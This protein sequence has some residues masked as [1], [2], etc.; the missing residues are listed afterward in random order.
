MQ[1]VFETLGIDKSADTSTIRKAYAKAIKQ[2]DPATEAARFQRIREAYEWA[3]QWAKRVEATAKTPPSVLVHGALDNTST[4]SVAPTAS[5]TR[6]TVPIDEAGELAQQVFREFVD[7]AYAPYA[8]P[9]G[10]ILAAYSHDVRL[11]SLDAKALFEQAVLVRAFARPIDVFLLDKACDLFIWETSSRHLAALRPDLVHRM[12]RQQTLRRLLTAG[13]AADHETLA[14]AVRLYTLIKRKPTTRVEPWQIANANRVLD[15]HAA[16][17]HELNERFSQEAFDWWRQKLRT[18]ASLS[19]AYDERHAQE[20]K[21]IPPRRQ[22]RRSRGSPI[23]W[24][25]IFPFLG[26][27][28]ILGSHF[29][30]PDQKATLYEATPVSTEA[31]STLPEPGKLEKNSTS[32]M[33]AVRSPEAENQ[34]GQTYAVNGVDDATYRMAVE[35][36]Q[37]SADQGYPP[38]LYNLGTM[39]EDGHGVAQNL[40]LAVD[41]FKQS[42][43]KGYSVAQFHLGVLYK[44]G[45]GVKGSAKLAHA[46]WEKAAEQGH[47]VAQFNLGLSFA[48]GDGAKQDYSSA[49]RWWR[50]AAMRGNASAQNGMGWLCERGLGIAQDT[51]AA[52]TWYRSAASQGDVSAQV[53]LASMY[54]RGVGVRKDPMVAYALLSV[55]ASRSDST[56]KN[57]SIAMEHVARGLSKEQLGTATELAGKLRSRNSFLA[58]LDAAVRLD[59]DH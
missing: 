21:P 30:L 8:A 56:Q 57:A 49:A 6:K 2:C 40:P 39:Y 14:E 4:V 47:I 5:N 58:K 50:A 16:F 1:W 32:D 7:A 36:F 28:S 44:D 37:R 13:N 55:A 43:V 19:A 51:N 3:L 25:I 53:N 27:M 34:L 48:K 52:I 18:N 33:A 46:W 35:L 41:L 42:A 38:A 54:E 17:K 26:V 20:T 24:M 15:R 12:Q 45:R 29:S 10:A 31:K 9:M 11:T 22:Q 59:S 23:G